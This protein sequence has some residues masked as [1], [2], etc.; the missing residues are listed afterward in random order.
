VEFRSSEKRVKIEE[1]VSDKGGS[2]LIDKRSLISVHD[3]KG[4]NN[5]RT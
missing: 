1:I 2:G 4:D 3:R 5:G